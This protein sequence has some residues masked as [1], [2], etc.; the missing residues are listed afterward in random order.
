[1]AI[2]CPTQSLLLDEVK[3]VVGGHP[4]V[5]AKIVITRG[6][7]PRGYAAPTA[8][9]PLRVVSASP[10]QPQ[11][12]QQGIHARICQLR[13]SHQPALAG[14]KHLNRLENVLAR[15]EWREPEIR[16]GLLLDCDEN[17]IGG[18]M[19]NLFIAKNGVFYTPDL[20]RCGVAGV[21][22]ARVI[23]IAHRFGVACHQV[24]LPLQRVLE[25]DELFFVNSLIGVW[26]VVKLDGHAWPI[27]KLSERLRAALQA[28]DATLVSVLPASGI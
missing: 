27:G 10:Y 16:E 22:R 17:A 12:A 15:A 23:S 8:Q 6:S 11:P 19:S 18:T 5:A 25:A 26:P 21:T 7:G 28:E 9:A 2:N 3:L 24:H 13:L 14:A 20:S 1:M 4:S